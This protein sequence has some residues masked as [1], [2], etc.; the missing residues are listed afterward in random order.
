MFLKGLHRARL[1]KHNQGCRQSGHLGL[2]R[3]AVRGLDVHTLAPQETLL[4]E[5]GLE[6]VEIP[7]RQWMWPPEERAP[8]SMLDLLN[9][10]FGLILEAVTGEYIPTNVS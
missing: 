9:L 3:L 5:G 7:K 1:S 4:T 10:W 2:H 8:A 6:A